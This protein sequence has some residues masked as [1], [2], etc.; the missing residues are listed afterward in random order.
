MSVSFINGRAAVHEVL[1]FMND[2][3]Q[4]THICS[5]VLGGGAGWGSRRQASELYQGQFNCMIVSARHY[6]LKHD[7]HSKKLTENSHASFR[8][9]K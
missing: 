9:V 3:L 6:F 5:M 8:G 7:S 4:G 2:A 1:D